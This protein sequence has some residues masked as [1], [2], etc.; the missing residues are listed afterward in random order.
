MT[1]EETF[2]ITDA[3]QYSEAQKVVV[4]K[5]CIAIIATQLGDT[6][7]QINGITLFPSLTPN[8]TAG[9]SITIADPQGRIY[10]G[11]CQIQFASPAGVNPLIELVQVFV[12]SIEL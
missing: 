5:N 3:I 2:N 8:L 6:I 12:P 1:T 11:K 7:A 9:D 10:K 4:E